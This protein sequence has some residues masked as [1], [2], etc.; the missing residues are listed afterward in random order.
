M[1]NFKKR[2]NRLLKLRKTKKA[3]QKT[4]KMIESEEYKYYQSLYDKKKEKNL[5][6]YETL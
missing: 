6:P 1:I 5:I 2:K 4:L 3:L